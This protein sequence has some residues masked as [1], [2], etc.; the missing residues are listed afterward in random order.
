MVSELPNDECMLGGGDDQPALGRVMVRL[1]WMLPAILGLIAIALISELRD[2]HPQPLD[3]EFLA[4]DGHFMIGG[5]HIVIP[6]GSIRMSGQGAQTFSLAPAK[7]VNWYDLMKAKALNPAQPMEIS[8]ATIHPMYSVEG[9]LKEGRRICEAL[10]RP[11]ARTMCF[12]R[13]EGPLKD[14][15]EYRFEIIAASHRDHLNQHSMSGFSRSLETLV[16]PTPGLSTSTYYDCTRQPGFCWASIEAL[17]GVLAYW[18]AGSTPARG[19]Y[20]YLKAQAEGAAVR[21]LL[22]RGMGPELDPTF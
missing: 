2:P 5:Q 13:K 21:E 7:R 12:G 16:T 8:E 9:D 20:P 22:S 4:S 11:W 6:I 1:F 19:E 15:P 14:L 3:A 17:P 18:S 10:K